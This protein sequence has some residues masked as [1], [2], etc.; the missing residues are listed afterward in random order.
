MVFVEEEKELEREKEGDGGGGGLRD[1][2]F[3]SWRA[4]KWWGGEG[5]VLDLILECQEGVR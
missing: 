2:G 1:S 5:L 3:W 4:W